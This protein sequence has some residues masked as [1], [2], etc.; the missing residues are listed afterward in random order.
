M[1]VVAALVAHLEAPV[2]VHPR[3][4]SFH[5]PP[6]S[7]QLLAGFDASPCYPGGY[8]PL[9]ERL[10]ASREVVS[11]VGMQ[12]LRALAR[13][14]TR[15]LAD[16]LNG[17]HGLFQDLGVVDVGSC[18]DHRERDASSV[19]H[20][21][22]LRARFALIRRIR[23]GSLAPRGRPHSPSP[24]TPSPSRCGRLLPND[25]GACGAAAPTHPPHAIP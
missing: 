5:H 14:S 13:A 6:V 17:I 12:L 25:P 8:A 4:S 10:A 18:M 19:D 16:R 11:L 15:R 23:A 24:K 7:S 21:M 1:D 3:Q 2:A 9:P 20:N 22:A